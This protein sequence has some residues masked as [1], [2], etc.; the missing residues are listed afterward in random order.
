MKS[1]YTLN[2]KAD[3]S[4]CFCDLENR[5]DAGEKL[6][7]VVISTKDK[8]K[9]RTLSQNASLHK[10]CSD[11]ASKMT[12][13]GFTQKE[14]VG[15]FKN[16]FVL[17]VTGEMI[18]A[19]FRT[20]GEA[21]YRKDSTAK[22]T[23]VEMQEVYRVVDMRFGEICGIRLEWPSVDSQFENFKQQGAV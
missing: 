20:V 11:L 18:K 6:T 22:L 21:M 7:I 2:T 16:G 9:V 23:T 17:P 5:F 14:L 12:D 19:I 13:S 8:S 10:Y 4:A 3:V 1:E 15:S